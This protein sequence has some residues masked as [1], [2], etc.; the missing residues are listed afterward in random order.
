MLRA[1]VTP[2]EVAVFLLADPKQ[3]LAKARVLEEQ[4]VCNF[5]LTTSGRSLDRRTFAEIVKL[6]FLLHAEVCLRILRLFGFLAPEG[7]KTL[8]GARLH[9]YH[10]GLETSLFF[11]KDML[12]V[13]SLTASGPLRQPFS[14]KT[15]GVD[16][17]PLNIL[18]S[19]RRTPLAQAPSLPR[20]NS[21]NVCRF[22]ALCRTGR[23]SWE[24][25]IEVFRY[26]ANGLMVEDTL[27]WLAGGRWRSCYGH[28]GGLIVAR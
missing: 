26:V 4:G 25:R 16:S 24:A 21:C 15:L 3:V 7:A 8:K 22:T 23:S 14:F 20:G 27:P 2:K 5:S 9:R 6:V 13:A 10:H 17:V 1:G 19:I 18:R 12:L 28:R 11:S